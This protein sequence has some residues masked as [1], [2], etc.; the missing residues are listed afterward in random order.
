MATRRTAKRPE[1]SWFRPA[2]VLAALLIANGIPCSAVENVKTV[3]ES[4]IAREY[5]AF[6]TVHASDDNRLMQFVRNPIAD[7]DLNETPAPV[8][9]Q[10]TAEV[11]QELGYSDDEIALLTA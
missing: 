2:A 11:L 8:L 6:S 9:G 1:D 10:H 4:D 3:A 5:A 7:E